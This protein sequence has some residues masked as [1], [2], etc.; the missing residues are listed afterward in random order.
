MFVSKPDE[1]ILKTNPK[2]VTP[3]L[4]IKLSKDKEKI[5]KIISRMNRNGSR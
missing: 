2:D 3:V 1:E 5:E 4:H